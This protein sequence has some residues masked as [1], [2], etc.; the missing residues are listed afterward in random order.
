MARCPPLPFKGPASYAL[1]RKAKVDGVLVNAVFH[2]CIQSCLV[3]LPP[4]PEYRWLGRLI[5][6]LTLVLSLLLC[7][8][9]TPQASYLKSFFSFGAIAVHQ[10]LCP[11]G[12][13][14]SEQCPRLGALIVFFIVS[15]YCQ[16]EGTKE[17]YGQNDPWRLLWESAGSLLSLWD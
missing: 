4:G 2:A 17:G 14:S 10:G 1:L 12:G 13:L 8:Q 16:S 15:E 5:L 6:S 7:F 3:T 9:H 11:V